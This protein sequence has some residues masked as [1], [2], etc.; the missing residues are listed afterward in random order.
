MD[1]CK[2]FNDATKELEQGMLIP[3]AISVYPDK[4]FDFILK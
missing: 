1:F 2:K 4:S 3:V